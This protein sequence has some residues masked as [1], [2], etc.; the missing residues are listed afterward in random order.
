[1]LSR[2]GELITNALLSEGCSVN[3]PNP[4]ITSDGLDV[5]LLSDGKINDSKLKLFYDFA[6]ADYD[7]SRVV[8]NAKYDYYFFL[9]EDMVIESVPVDGIGKPGVDRNNI[10]ADDLIKISRV[11]VYDNKL[12]GA[13]LYIWK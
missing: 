7:G 8:L 13:R 11:V 10:V 12:I 4:W 5:G 6:Q 3:C 9:D 2:D 1:M